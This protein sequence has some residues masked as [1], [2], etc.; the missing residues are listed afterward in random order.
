MFFD[1]DVHIFLMLQYI[2]FVVAVHNFR[3]CSTCFSMLHYIFF[4]CC[5]IRIPMLH[6]IV[7]TCLVMLHLKCFRA[8]GTG[9]VVGERGALGQRGQ[10]HGGEAEDRDAVDAISFP[11]YSDTRG[12]G[13]PFNF[14]YAGA[15][16]F[17]MENYV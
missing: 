15:D 9:S 7:F 1:V 16:G 12:D 6:F 3:C 8:L 13:I 5:S 2:I 14:Q 10:G 11:F 17:T 4:P